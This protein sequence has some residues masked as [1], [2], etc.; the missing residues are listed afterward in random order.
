M[1]NPTI[2]AIEVLRLEKRLDENLQY[3]MD[4]PP[5]Y[6]TIPFDIQP[7]KLLPG[8][9]VPLNTIRVPLKPRP[10]RHK[11]ERKSLRGV[12]LPELKNYE[13]A[14]LKDSVSDV[15][16]YERWDMMKHYRESVHDHDLKEIVADLKQHETEAEDKREVVIAAKK[17]VK[18]RRIPGEAGGKDLKK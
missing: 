11:W 3:L 15:K 13:Y 7:I 2:Q 14:Q 17:L 16:P 9:K 6:S 8:M 18:T 1:Y 5:E 12:I 10:W 4:C